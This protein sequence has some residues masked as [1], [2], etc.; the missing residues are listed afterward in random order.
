VLADATVPVPESTLRLVR[1]ARPGTP[2][3][4]EAVLAPYVEHPDRELGLAVLWALSADGAG[5]SALAEEAFD[6]MLQAEAEHAAR[7][8]AAIAAVEPAPVLERAI[9]D[10]LDLLRQRVFALLTL[11][12][13]ADAIHPAALGLAGEDE[14]RRALALEILEV[15]LSRDEAA[16]VVPVVRTDLPE[17]ERLQMLQRS[18]TVPAADR[19]SVMAE[20]AADSDG[21]WRSFWLQSCAVYETSRA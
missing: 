17:S 11:R 18:L 2:E 4:A 7:C 21:R 10:E 19:S 14:G 1:A 5:A 3:Q 16:L 6:R 12:Y 13:G 20:I 8:L 9:R 15:K